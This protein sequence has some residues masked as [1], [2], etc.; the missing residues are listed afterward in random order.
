M[1]MKK[2]ILCALLA[3]PALIYG[4]NYGPIHSGYSKDTDKNLIKQ[5]IKEVDGKIFNQPGV[6]IQKW[7]RLRAQMLDLE[8][9]EI[10]N[11][12]KKM[13]IKSRTAYSEVVQTM[14]KLAQQL[15]NLPYLENGLD[16]DLKHTK[17]WLALKALQMHF[18]AEQL[19]LIA[20]AT[21]SEA[22][23]KLAE[24]K[25]KKARQIAHTVGSF[26]VHQLK[27]KI[28]TG[29]SRELL[30]HVELKREQEL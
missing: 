8:A 3:I 26:E 2:I 9:E 22:A 24:H 16:K 5:Y 19:S 1:N 12:L 15:R 18:A 6:M 13:P 25:N 30:S 29:L 7:T 27:S 17:K 20:K 10:N 14:K 21:G 11:A 23:Q 28:H 4:Y